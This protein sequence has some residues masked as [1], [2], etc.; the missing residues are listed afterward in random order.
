MDASWGGEESQDLEAGVLA[1]RSFWGERA[2]LNTARGLAP[3]SPRLWESRAGEG[4]GDLRSAGLTAGGCAQQQRSLRLRRG[5]G[6]TAD[7]LG[8][9]DVRASVHIAMPGGRLGA[10]EPVHGA[11]S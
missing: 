4:A 5:T 2:G 11:G 1:G 7:P 6:P 3:R 8:T 10:C 9:G